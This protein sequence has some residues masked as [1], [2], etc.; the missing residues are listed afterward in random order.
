[1]GKLEIPEVG[2]LLNVRNRIYQINE[3][4]KYDNVKGPEYFLSLEDIETSESLQIILRSEK[5]IEISPTFIKFNDF[6]SE[7][8]NIDSPEVFDAFIKALKWSVNSIFYSDA[9]KS[10]FYSNIKLNYFQLD[11]LIRALTMPKISLLI[12]DDVGLGKTIEAGLIIQ[13]LTLKNKIKRTLIVCPAAL[14]EQWQRE[15]KEKFS[16][17]FKIMNL[18]EITK[19]FKEYGVNVNPWTTYPRLITSMDFIK[20]E[21]YLNMFRATTSGEKNIKWDFLVVDEAHNIMPKPTNEYYLDS[22]RTKAIRELSK[23]FPHK[24]FLTATPHN[25]NTRSF[26]ALLEMLDPK[27]FNRGQ[28]KLDNIS[29]KRLYEIM[30]RRLKNEINEWN[31]IEDSKFPERFIHEFELNSE[32]DEMKLFNYLN[33]YIHRMNDFQKT[34]SSK[35][36]INLDFTLMVLKKRLLSSYYAFYNSLEKYINKN[37]ENVI[38]EKFIDFTI[39][40]LE[41]ENYDN[42]FD[43]DE[44][45]KLLLSGIIENYTNDEINKKLI[46]DMYELSSKLKNEDEQKIKKIYTFIENKLLE[47][48]SFNNERLIIFTEYK[49]TLDYIVEKLKKRYGENRVLSLYGGMN[50]N[51]REIV[52]KKFE[53]DP[54][55][56]EA[57]ILVATDAAS[58][59]INLQYYCHSL[60][61]YDIPWNPIRLEQRNG[62]IHRVGQDKDVHI[63]HFIY[64]NNEDYMILKNV[65]KKIDTIKEDIDSLNSLI[66]E[67]THMAIKEKLLLKEDEISFDLKI[68]STLVKQKILMKNEI[69]HKFDEMKKKVQYS[70]NETKY[71][72]EITPSNKKLVLSSALKILTGKNQLE[73]YPDEKNIYYIKELPKNWDNLKSYI[74]DEKGVSKKISF[75]SKELKSSKEHIHLS[76]PLMKRSI[77]FFKSQIWNF[78]N[79]KIN[80][81]TIKTSELLEDP[82]VRIYL[83]TSVNDNKLDK[84]TEDIDIINGYLINNTFIEA[85][86]GEKIVAKNIDK[87]NI[88]FELSKKIQ[89][90]LRKN[91]NTINTIIEKRKEK[92]IEKV[93]E[94][95][96]EKKEKEIKNLEKILIN[97]LNEIDILINELNKMI[98][99]RK[100]SNKNLISL[101]DNEITLNEE[102]KTI[103]DDIAYLQR[104]KE[105]LKEEIKENIKELKNRVINKEIHMLPI[106]VEVIIPESF[107]SGGII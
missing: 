59:G 93:I 97:Q 105:L 35:E 80:K 90:L 78:N 31:F 58:E 55:K 21:K 83:K 48:G 7:I 22:D 40:K 42:D 4:E 52:K 63:Y 33:A 54:Y 39:N 53:S 104:K 49:D 8:K 41:N 20:Q 91:E 23:I 88:L 95:W 62:R 29:K 18:K 56:E 75:D 60:I 6:F 50:Y 101:F 12:A 92:Y 81:F 73:K 82:L 30:V 70:L 1:V 47:N 71:K 103:K 13:E 25:G 107:L 87:E 34:L 68:K 86:E 45:E 43:K 102:I 77:N 61:H 99:K 84:I 16:M 3:I 24:V 100:K 51:E 2:K 66:S 98:N 32:E 46:Y 57:R 10:P 67:E 9:I 14:Q 36:K 79:K 28:S 37:Y 106:A 44:D 94:L 11:P 19:I 17:D 89:M 76:H 96:N 15:M 38:D 64:N 27:Y 72:Y 26:I 69:L 65:I 85:I 74:K 5:E